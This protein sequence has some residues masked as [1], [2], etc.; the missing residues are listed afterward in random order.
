MDQFFK[1]R[2]TRVIFGMIWGFGLA[3]IF[4]KACNDRKCMIIKAPPMKDIQD[5]KFEFK[6]K[7]YKYKP[8]T[9]DCSH[10]KEIIEP[11]QNALKSG[12]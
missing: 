10:A 8:I 3:S 7:C 6:E 1:N 5:N 12:I 2:M 9:I 11:Y 4:Y